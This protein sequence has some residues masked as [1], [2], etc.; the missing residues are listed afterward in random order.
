MEFLGQGLNPSSNCDLLCSCGNTRSFS[1]LCWAGDQ[2]HTSIAIWATE[3]RFLTYLATAG[4]PEHFVTLYTKI[5][6]KWIQDLNVRR[7]TIKLLE[8]ETGRT[9]FNI[10][11]S[12]IF[13]D[14]PP[15]VIKIKTKINKW[16]LIKLKGFGI[17]KEIISETKRQPT[18]QEKIFAKEAT[19]KGLISKIYNHLMQLYINKFFKWTK[20]LK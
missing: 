11:H 6:S 1:P 7:D 10:N 17:E 18:E 8:A 12:N 13:L 14:P 16:D 2:T 4:T 3:V 20:D 5:N 15:R 9:L 19:D